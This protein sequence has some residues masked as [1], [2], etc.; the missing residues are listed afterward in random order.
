MEEKYLLRMDEEDEESGG[1]EI[2]LLS[3]EKVMDGLIKR[4]IQV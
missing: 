1:L 4:R 3:A 2:T